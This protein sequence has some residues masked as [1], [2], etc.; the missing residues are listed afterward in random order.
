MLIYLISGY[1]GSGKD[2]AGRVFERLGFRRYGF[3]D[4]LKIESAK[5]HGYD[6][7]LTQTVQGKATLVRSTKTHRTAPVR[8]F[9]IEDSAKAKQ[10]HADEGYWAKLVADQIEKETPKFVVI[11]DWRYNSEYSTLRARFPQA[12]LVRIRVVRPSVQPSPDPSEHN[13]DSSP[14]DFTIHNNSTLSILS[15]QCYQI[16]EL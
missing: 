16:I 6:Y 13:L 3:A 15:E 12:K 8:T 10:T 11:T 5:N 1:A 4:A 2:A 14:V 9:L 7:A